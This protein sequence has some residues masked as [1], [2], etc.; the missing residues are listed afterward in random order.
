[1]HRRGFDSLILH[2]MFK[3]VR[4][5]Q[6]G[7]EFIFCPYPVTVDKRKSWGDSPQNVQEFPNGVYLKTDSTGN[8][9]HG[10]QP[11]DTD[12]KSPLGWSS[13]EDPRRFDK[14]DIW[15]DDTVIPAM[16]VTSVKG[17]DGFMKYEFEEPS[18]LCH[19]CN[20]DG[21]IDLDDGWVSKVPSVTKDYEV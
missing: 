1:M 10:V 3:L 20:P 15:I 19:N 13:T 12:G 7:V 8:I 2:I 18:Y 14:L 21:G 17:K 5:R 9:S 11:N 6:R 4:S 16:S